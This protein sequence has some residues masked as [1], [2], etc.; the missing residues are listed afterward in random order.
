[1]VGSAQH[2]LAKWLAGMLEPVL[3]L[4]CIYESFPFAK[5]IQN[6][7][8]NLKTSFFCSF[9]ISNL[10]TNIP[11]DE[12]ITICA[13]ALYHSHLDTTPFPET[14]FLKLMH[15]T[16]NWVQFSSNNTMYQSESRRKT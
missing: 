5:V 3:K 6:T 1:M 4:Y 7:S 2:H 13:D 10:Y 9:D 8:I 14:V 16:T 12:T 15:I 11:L